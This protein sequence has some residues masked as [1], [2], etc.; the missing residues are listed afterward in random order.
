M[1]ISRHA[2]PRI[3]ACARVPADSR[4]WSMEKSLARSASAALRVERRT[5]PARAPH[6]CNWAIACADRLDLRVLPAP[7]AEATS[8]FRTQGLLNLQ[9]SC[10]RGNRTRVR[11]TAADAR[12]VPAFQREIPFPLHPGP[13]LANHL[14]DKP[15]TGG[16]NAVHRAYQSG[17]LASCLGIALG[18]LFHCC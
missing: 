18:P 6:C 14:P 10:C 3:S 2:L 17:E 5:R 11:S 7:R 8:G 9:Q 16:K 4:S 12:P 1:R 15:P 13:V